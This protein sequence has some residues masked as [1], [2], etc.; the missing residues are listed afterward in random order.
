MDV[1]CDGHRVW[2]VDL[3]DHTSGPTGTVVPWPTQLRGRLRGA[4][5]VSIRDT[6]HGTTLVSDRVVFDANPGGPDLVDP[7]GR[8]LAVSKYGLLRPSFESLS[9]A[10]LET[11]LDQA[12]LVLDAL[13]DDCGVPAFVSYGTLLGA[14]RDGRLISHDLDIDLGYLSQASTPVDV[15]RESYSMQRTLV[16]KH[17]WSIK[18]KNG[19]LLQV[20]FPQEDGSRRNIDIFTAF[21]SDGHVLAVHDTDFTG[22]TDDVLPLREVTLNGRPVPAP[23]NAEAFLAAAYGPSWRVPDPT[24]SYD[25]AGTRAR[26][27]AWFAGPRA[28]RDRWARIYRL[29]SDLPGTPSAFAHAVNA[30]LA[31]ETSVIDVGCGNG[32]DSLF[33]ARRGHSVQGFDAVP[34]VLGPPRRRARRN[35]L[36][37]TFERLDLDSVREVLV[38]GAARARTSDPATTAVYARF[39]LHV[40]RPASRENF[41]R[42]CAMTL[43]HGG[44]C[45]VE[46]RTPQDEGLPKRYPTLGRRH[47][48]PDVIRAEAE[49]FGA[50][51]VDQQVSTGFGVLDDEDPVLCRMVLQW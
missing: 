51:V 45:Y 50:T 32:R 17:G 14:V 48:D 7:Q 30:Q 11:Y 47:V 23:R 16:E 46:F 27:L 25:E 12:S 34:G 26:M 2:S 35:D 41:W 10:T 8:R 6:A 9:T 1:V 28:E 37:A 36:D 22:D 33:F 38:A 4:S 49:S 3:S 31:A 18:R 39:L 20:F 24:F 40:L 5:E 13:R 29:R 43:R 15:M 42:L 19:G 21:I 44:R